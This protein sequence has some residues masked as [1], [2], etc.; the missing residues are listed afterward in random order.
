MFHDTSSL[1]MNRGCAPVY[2]TAFA[3]AANVNDDTYT[4][5][6]GCTPDTSSARCSAPV[7]LDN[8]TAPGQPGQRR[9]IGLERVEL[10]PGGRHPTAVER[11][12]QRITLGGADVGRAEEDAFG[13]GDNPVMMTSGRVG[14][15]LPGSDHRAGDH[16]AGDHGGDHCDGDHGDHHAKRSTPEADSANST[17]GSPDG[18]TTSM[19]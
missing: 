8:A 18:S 12:Q 19:P 7:P 1:S 17:N 16:G 9:Q 2:T 15:R 5:S 13:H 11:P 4:S 10:G 6:P 3:D 14:G